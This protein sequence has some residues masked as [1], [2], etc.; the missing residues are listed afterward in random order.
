MINWQ[1]HAHF[2]QK[3]W[4]ITK[5]GLQF[6][7]MIKEQGEPACKAKWKTGRMWAKEDSLN[8]KSPDSWYK[9]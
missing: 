9:K 8:R 7:S 5:T 2:C 3:A 1:H 6:H 4:G